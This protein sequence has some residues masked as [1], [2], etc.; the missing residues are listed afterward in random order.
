MTFK[1]YDK[2][3]LEGFFKCLLPL[4]NSVQSYFGVIFFEG[5]SILLKASPYSQI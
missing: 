1:V 2:I 3:M 5:Y 4:S